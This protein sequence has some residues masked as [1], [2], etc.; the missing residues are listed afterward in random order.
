MTMEKQSWRKTILTHLAEDDEVSVDSLH[1]AS[2]DDADL[3]LAM[4]AAEDLEL[5]GLAW[6]DH[7]VIKPRVGKEAAIKEAL[8]SC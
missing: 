8:A 6:D 4:R 5:E 2:E 3:D 7:G 1:E